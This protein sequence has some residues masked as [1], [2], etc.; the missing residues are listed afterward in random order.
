[1][2]GLPDNILRL[3]RPEDRAALGKAG[4][5][6]AEA[7][8]KCKAGM[9][10]QL[11]NEI[12]NYLRLRDI[13]FDWDA[14]HARRRGTRGAPDFMFAIMGVPC[15]VEAKTE[16]GRVSAEQEKA[17]EAMRANGWRVI[18]ATS[19]MDVKALLDLITSTQQTTL[20]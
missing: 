18:I 4:V 11:Q 3:M 19:I 7:T 2:K 13:W 1:M 9:E 15:A 5:T 12:R 14:T 6:T 20:P 8:E 10:K 16:K 17:H